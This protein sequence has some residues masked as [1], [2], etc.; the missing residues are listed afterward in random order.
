MK[1]TAHLVVSKGYSRAIIA[2]QWINEVLT[3]C[4]EHNQAHHG[5]EYLSQ[6]K[7]RA[8]VTVE[9]EVPDSVF[10][11]PPTPVLPATAVKEN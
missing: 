1:V 7:D 6:P 8:V 9:F 4:E 11:R 2:S 10:D 5:E 3:H